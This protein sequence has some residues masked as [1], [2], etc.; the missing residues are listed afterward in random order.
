MEGLKIFYSY[1]IK[2]LYISIQLCRLS[3][4][5]YLNFS[6]KLFFYI[7]VKIN[8]LPSWRFLLDLIYG[9]EVKSYSTKI[10]EPDNHRDLKNGKNVVS[11]FLRFK[12]R[13]SNLPKIQ[14]CNLFLPETVG[15]TQCQKLPNP[16]LRWQFFICIKSTVWTVPTRFFSRYLSTVM[17]KIIT[18]ET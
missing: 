16:G 5:T 13:S 14:T 15:K 18:L 11:Q 1:K 2:N 7:N 10:C 9:N 8:Y 3:A 12:F 4:Q 6:Y 17:F